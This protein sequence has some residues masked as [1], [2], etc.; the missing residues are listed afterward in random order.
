MP[1]SGL[2]EPWPGLTETSPG[3]TEPWPDPPE[4]WPAFGTAQSQPFSRAIRTA[5]ALFRAA[6]FWMAVER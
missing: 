1:V 5:S 4:P 6:S 2:A 3:L